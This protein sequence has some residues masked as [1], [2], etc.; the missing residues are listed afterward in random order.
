[1]T[2]PAAGSSQRVRVTREAHRVPSSC[3]PRQ[4]GE[5]IV[6]FLT[7][8]SEG[9]VEVS[10]F[11]APDMK[12][13]SVSEWS[14]GAGKRHFV[15]HGYD[16]REL[17]S[18]FERRAA[19]N[20]RISLLEVDVSYEPGRELGH[21]AY[22]LERG[23]DDLPESDPIVHGKGAIDCDTGKIAVWSMSHD[24]RFQKA[25]PICP[26]EPKPSGLAIACARA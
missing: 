15:S 4:V 7:A 17:E 5:L 16:P 3:A 19:Q 8:I 22:V 23:A 18:Y 13:Y 6:G 10:R 11:F 2:S 20:E 26:G 21:V 24:S 1:M 14:R 25:P 9:S 12:W